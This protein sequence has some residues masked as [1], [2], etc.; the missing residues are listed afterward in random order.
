MNAF[1]SPF[2]RA[3]NSSMYLKQESVQDIWY[4]ERGFR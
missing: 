3:A 2:L 4:I 1:S